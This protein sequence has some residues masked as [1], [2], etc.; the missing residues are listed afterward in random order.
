MI[1][2]LEAAKSWF[3]QGCGNATKFAHYVVGVNRSL[4]VCRKC[5]K[6]RIIGFGMF[7]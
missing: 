2:F 7:Y 6:S 1:T 3:C 4:V 5:Q